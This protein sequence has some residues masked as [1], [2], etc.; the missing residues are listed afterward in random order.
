MVT[1]QTGTFHVENTVKRTMTDDHAETSTEAVALLDEEKQRNM[2]AKLWDRTLGKLW[3][4]EPTSE[5]RLGTG[6]TRLLTPPQ[7]IFIQ[8][9]PFAQR[10]GL[11][12]LDKSDQNRW[13]KN[14]CRALFT[15]L[16]LPEKWINNLKPASQPKRNNHQ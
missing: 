2:T 15:L 7:K 4:S 9:L 3:E 6:L 10:A 11:I 12:N 5:V 13:E 1:R 8:P 16:L 14:R